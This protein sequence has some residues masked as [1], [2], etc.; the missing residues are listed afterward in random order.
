MTRPQRH[1]IALA[2][3]LALAT[4]PALAQPDAA[5]LA[6]GRY[7]GEVVGAC[8]AC[9]DSVTPTMQPIPGMGM[10][11]GR[12]F[13]EGVFRAVAPNITQDRDTGIGAWTD[14][15]IAAAIR[16]GHRPDGSLIG[17]PMPVESYRRISDRDLAAL[18]AWLRTVPP[19]RNTP[20]D[21]SRYSFPL[22]A[23]GPPVT[24]VPEPPTNDPVARGRYLAVNLAHCM[25]CHSGQRATGGA[26]PDRRGATGLALEG[27]WGVVRAR[28]ISPHPDMGIG[29]W[30]DAQI[31]AAITTGVSADGRPLQPPMAFRG[32]VWARMDPA[33]MAAIVAYLR[34]LPPQDE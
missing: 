21:R 24:T 16:D 1:R 25:D 17:P 5:L 18:I 20:T 8:G 34:S 6:R 4:S 19:V 13:D 2:A 33:D 7:I 27:P 11:G 26:D 3:L 29:R 32:P 10:A 31:V 14:A 15:Q 9:H 22:A 30:T 12:V 28:N 23:M